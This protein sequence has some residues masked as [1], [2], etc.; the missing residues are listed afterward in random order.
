VRYVG[1]RHALRVLEMLEEGAGL[2]AQLGIQVT[3][4]LIEQE[5]L[6]LMHDRPRHRRALLLPAGNLAGPPIQQVADL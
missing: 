6:C 1:R 4:R 3:Q 5:C 2:Q